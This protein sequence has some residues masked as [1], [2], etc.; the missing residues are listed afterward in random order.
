[1]R[2]FAPLRPLDVR[3]LAGPAI[4]VTVPAGSHLI[5]EDRM[6]G[7]F[8]VIQSGQAALWRRGRRIA[9]LSEG[10]CFGEIDPVPS[11]PQRF[12]VIADSPMRVLTFSAFGIQRLCS[13]IP[14]TRERILDALVGVLGR[15][16]LP[17]PE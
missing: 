5:C 2:V 1:M 15:A 6:A 12:S 16:P 3:S 10:D 9:A 4:G 11:S 8:F 7:T 13:A 14:G 17:L